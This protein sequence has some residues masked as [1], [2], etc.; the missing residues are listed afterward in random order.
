MSMISC[1]KSA[2]I[3]GNTNSSP[4]NLPPGLFL[5]PQEWSR[6]IRGSNALP[7]YL[8]P[9]NTEECTYEPA[10]SAVLTN[11]AYTFDHSKASERLAFKKMALETSL[12]I[13]EEAT[14]FVPR[15]KVVSQSVE[16]D[17]GKFSWTKQSAKLN[18]SDTTSYDQ[19]PREL[20]QIEWQ[21]RCGSGK[22]SV[23]MAADIETLTANVKTYSEKHP[24]WSQALSIIKSGHWAL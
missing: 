19:S 14:R 18:K 1:H 8:I 10:E 24:E 13:D 20:Y 21:P 17:G 9:M 12:S 3:S 5:Y 22:T 7:S 23:R 2:K 16:V 11:L 15:P 6:F 4:W